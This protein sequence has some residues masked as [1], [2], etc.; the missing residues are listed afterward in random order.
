MSSRYEEGLRLIEESCGNGKD[1]VIAL[2]T[3]G[4]EPSGGKVTFPYVREVDAYYE[5]GVFYVTTWG[6][7]NKMQQIAQ[8]KEVA[9]TVCLQGISGNGIG[10]NLGWVLDPKNAE[11]RAKLRNAFAD[12]YDDANNEQ[13][14]NCVILAI[15][16]TRCSIFRDHG[17]VRYNMDFVNKVET[18]E[19]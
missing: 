9:F 12:W 2:S 6:K 18:A 11:L 1:N 10:E 14:E 5:D 16:I 17:A 15:R 19:V 3:I 13:D 4:M 7:S 8:N